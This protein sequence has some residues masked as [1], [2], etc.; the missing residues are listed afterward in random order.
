MGIHCRDVYSIIRQELMEVLGGNGVSE[1][2]S[3]V[4]LMLLWAFAISKGGPLET[5][6]LDGFVATW[7]LVVILHRDA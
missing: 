4:G 1:V 7:V 3:E 6:L 2:I 5:P